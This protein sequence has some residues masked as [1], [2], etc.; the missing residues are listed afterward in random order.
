M[1]D[2]L[3]AQLTKHNLP[4]L[5]IHP[6]TA[7]T[8]I[9]FLG[10]SIEVVDG[11]CIYVSQPGYIAAL[12]SNFEYGKA[13]SSPLPADFN[14]RRLTDL[15][16]RPLTELGKTEFLK[17][18]MSLTWLV[19]TRIDIQ[20]C[21]AH[22]QT[23]CQEPRAIDI[24]DLRHIIGYLASTPNLGIRIDVKDMQPYLYVDVGHATHADRKSHEGALVTLGINGPP[25]IWKSGK[26]KIVATSS[27]EAELIGVSDYA[28]LILVTRRLLEFLRVPVETPLTV[29]QDNTSTITVAYL[30]RP[31]IHARRRFIDIRFA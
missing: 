30:G 29:F 27:T 6:L 22:L 28:D 24:L 26:Q 18:V 20:V 3:Y 5:T 7:Q 2:Y 8:P 12:V 16:T 21:V 4:N 10:L 14:S 9:S 31:S 23:R 11:H 13:H 15:Q 25:I 17:M 19:R 1:R